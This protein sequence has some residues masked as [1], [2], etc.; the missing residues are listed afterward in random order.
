MYGDSEEKIGRAL[1]GR[2]QRYLICTKCGR[3][4]PPRRNP[5]GF[6]VRLQRKLRCA[7]GL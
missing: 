1:R 7:M 6:L 2:R 3:C 5:N 4:L